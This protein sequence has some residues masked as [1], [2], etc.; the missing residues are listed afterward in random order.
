MVFIFVYNSYSVYNLWHTLQKMVKVNRKMLI[1]QVDN[2]LW[3][4]SQI[5]RLFAEL[6]LK[7][8]KLNEMFSLIISISVNQ[9]NRTWLRNFKI[10]FTVYFPWNVQFSREYLLYEGKCLLKFTKTLYSFIVFLV[11]IFLV[12]IIIIILR[13]HYWLCMLRLIY[14]LNNFHSSKKY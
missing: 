9:S 8:V 14:C 13:I 11:A 5:F 4:I 7:N 1:S 10:I 2:K 3:G 12:I 6:A